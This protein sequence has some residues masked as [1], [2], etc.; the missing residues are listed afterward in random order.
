MRALLVGLTIAATITSSCAGA[1]G[2]AAVAAAPPVN[3]GAALGERSHE[4]GSVKVVASWVEG[5][6][7]RLR[8]TLDTHSV[9]L[10]GFDLKQL[11]RLRVDGSSWTSP[12]SWDAPAGGHHREGTLTFSDLDPRAVASARLI[13]LEVRDVA[14]PSHLLRW[15]RT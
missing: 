9:N 2:G 11:A 7:P 14:V 15:E 4:D 3:A 8:V 13:E 5:A 12:S 1:P 10:D 6:V